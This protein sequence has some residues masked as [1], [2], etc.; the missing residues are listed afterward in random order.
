MAKFKRFHVTA[1]EI[2]KTFVQL[3]R[4]NA[5]RAGVAVDIH[6]GNASAMPF[7]SDSFDLL[8]CRAAFKNFAQPVEALREMY[9]VLRTGGT[10]VV[11]DLRRDT[12]MA[13]IH[14]YVDHS[15]MGIVSR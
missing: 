10:G 6:E 4:E 13:A 11:I 15:G 12:T 14:E 9:R 7:A 5:A 2:S 8:V 1:L 3:A